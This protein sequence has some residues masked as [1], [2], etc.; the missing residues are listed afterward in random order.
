M[1]TEPNDAAAGA[2]D[3]N[4]HENALGCV[5]QVALPA[6]VIEV[7]ARRAAAMEGASWSKPEPWCEIRA[8]AEHLGCKVR[9]VYELVALNRI[10]HRKEG[11]RLLFRL[12]ELDTWVT[13]QSS[14]T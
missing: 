9:R 8:A 13:S 7:I 2:L 5:I 3:R 6:A 10:P 12:S 11:R 14:R 4:A 1:R